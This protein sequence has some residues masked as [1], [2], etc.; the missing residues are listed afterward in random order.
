MAIFNYSKISKNKQFYII[1]EIGVNHECSIKSA[2]KMISEAKKNGAHA[3]KFQTY[4]AGKLASKNSKAYWDIKKEK[5]KSQFELF[6]KFDKFSETD[7]KILSNYCKKLKID[8][9]STPFDLDAIDFLNPLVPLFKISSSDITNVPLLRKISKKGK[10]VLLS[11]GASAENEIKF[12]IKNLQFYKKIKIVLMHC[13]LNYP[14]QNVDA[15]LLMISHLKK[16]FKNFIIGYSDHTTPSKGMLN[17]STAYTMGANVIEKHFTLNKKKLGNDH[18]HSMDPKDLKT[19]VDNINKII[20]L[21]GNSNNKKY[22][23]S[24]VISRKNA[25]RGIF[26]KNTIKKNTKISEN[27]LITLRPNSGIPAEK[28][29]EVLKKKVKKDLK[30]GHNLKWSDIK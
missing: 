10:P 27:H 14:T 6:S 25:R 13:I 17:I 21:K 2:K 16:K 30:A 26:I 24:E 1:A 12:A 18:Y 7:Y 23:S 19:I 29:N 28:W 8:F 9:L 15:N 3:A 4:K 22:I 20:Q 11:T 5:T